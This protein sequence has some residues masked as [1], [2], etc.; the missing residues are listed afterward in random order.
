VM[1]TLNISSETLGKIPRK[2]PGVMPQ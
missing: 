1:Q 2:H